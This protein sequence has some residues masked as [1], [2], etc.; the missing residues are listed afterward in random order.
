MFKS[1]RVGVLDTH[2]IARYG[3]CLHLFEQPDITVVGSYGRCDIAMRGVSE[4]EFDLLLIGHLSEGMIRLG[5][6]GHS[7]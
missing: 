4:D 7:A 6:S 1:I 3:L 2:E 5:L